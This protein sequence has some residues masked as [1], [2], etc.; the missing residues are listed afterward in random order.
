MNFYLDKYGF[1]PAQ[2]KTAPSSELGLIVVIPCF[3]EP[4]LI[5]SLESLAK[6]DQTSQ[7]VEVII[8]VN[9]GE[10]DTIEAKLQN[11]KTVNEFNSWNQTSRGFVF[12]LIREEELPEKVAGVGLARKIGMDEA[13]AR[14]HQIGTD[15]IIVCFDADS[16]CSPNFLVEIENHFQTNEE[17]P[18][19]S[20]Y[21][22][23]PIAGEEFPKEVYA[24]IINYELHLRYYNQCLNYCGLPY[25]FHTVGSSMAVRSSAYQKQG[26]M[27]KRKAGEDFYFIHKIIALG[28]FT[29]L[30]SCKVIP[31]PRISD[32]V[33]F[34]TG[35]AIGDWVANKADHYLTYNFNSFHQIKSL[36]DNLPHFFE[37]KYDLEAMGFLPSMIDFLED[38]KFK[39]RLSEIRNNTTS[40]A[41]FEKRFY[42]WLDAFKV[43]K[44]I[45]LL[46]DEGLPNQDL[47][48]SCE[49]LR[50]KV[51][52]FDMVESDNIS[53]L[54]QFRQIESA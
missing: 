8:V 49:L 30:T 22:E 45:H 37:N 42:T 6:C 54:N 51:N 40:Y 15:G 9:S 25:A 23:H 4:N 39:D 7:K 3:N 17:S 53:M 26:G 33:P 24:G 32:R 36:V 34:G 31:S 43:L 21:F 46:R 41:A 28:G 19:C 1:L 5:Q 20:I 16:V 10:N 27:N 13:V 48:Q 14:F 35:K 2:I 44:I 11:Q 18:G 29:S 47:L 12:H 50:S 52:L 38:Q